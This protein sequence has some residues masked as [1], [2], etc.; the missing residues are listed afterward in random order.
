MIQYCSGK[1]GHTGVFLPSTHQC[2]KCKY[3][4]IFSL[5][6]TIL[7]TTYHCRSV[8]HHPIWNLHY[9]GMCKNQW[10]LYRLD[11]MNQYPVGIHQH[12]EVKT[13]I[14]VMQSTCPH[15]DATDHHTA[16]HLHWA[17]IQS[18]SYMCMNQ[19]YWCKS[20][21]NCLYQLNTHQYLWNDSMSAQLRLE[22]VHL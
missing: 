1:L 5:F 8:Y 13:T 16:V 17:D 20:G 9:T 22:S 3:I 18:Y 6:D 10:C 12:L 21:Y 19:W 7:L 4:Y 11:H 14:I 15:G 2:L